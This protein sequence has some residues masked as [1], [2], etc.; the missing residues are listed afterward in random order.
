MSIDDNLSV[1]TAASK[2]TAI[3]KVTGKVEPLGRFGHEANKFQK[4]IQNK[5]VPELNDLLNRQVNILSNEALLKTL[6]D[7]GAKVRA[8]KDQL[9]ELI[10]SRTKALNDAADLLASLSLG[11]P[12]S[13]G[14]VDTDKMEWKYGGAHLMKK[15]TQINPV[16]SDD[17]S[18][19]Q[20]ESSSSDALKLL[21]SRSEFP[22]K[23]TKVLKKGE[24]PRFV[25][26]H[27][28]KASTLTVEAKATIP[29]KPT[30]LFSSKPS[31][32]DHPKTDA[33]PPENMLKEGKFK[34]K[35]LDLQESLE[36]QK[37]QVAR[38]KQ[39][40]LDQAA[41]RLKERLNIGTKQQQ[42]IQLTGEQLM[43]Y[44]T[45]GLD[46]Y[47]ET[48]EEYE[49]EEVFDEAD[50]NDGGVNFTITEYENN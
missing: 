9:E 26:S 39:T 4:E 27:S 45:T 36:L 17:D 22:Q 12:S 43:A 34:A 1:N 35:T 15:L 2:V 13:R 8:K 37:E 44:R 49:G 16:D 32:P 47:D 5:S 23:N 33:I 31:K 50:T 11:G 10:A 29:L 25:P 46:D 48:H 28:I 14:N 6:P 3:K 18:D 21:A 42:P 38:L 30:D 41:A 24:K 7:K 19:D 40:Q 20:E